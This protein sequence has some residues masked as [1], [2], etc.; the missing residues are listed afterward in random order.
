[1]SAPRTPEIGKR[2]VALARS[3]G[4]AIAI[5]LIAAG[6][7]YLW[8]RL[9][10]L[11]TLTISGELRCSSGSP[12]Q[13]VWVRVTVGDHGN[14][15]FATTRT[16]ADPVDLTITYYWLTIKARSYILHI[17]CGGSKQNWA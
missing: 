4:T 2:K 8:L 7:V 15:G 12:V 16:G 6:G 5:A 17:G 3:A 10:G 11:G 9:P 1:M 14:S 13:G